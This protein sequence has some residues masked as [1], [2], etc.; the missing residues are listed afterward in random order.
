[1][2]IRSFLAFDIS[3]EMKTKLASIIS[4]LSGKVKG[5]KWVDPSL[6]HCTIRFFGNVE[7]DMLRGEVSKVIASEVR[8]Q[9]P[10]N[11][12]GR[13]IGVFPNW[14]YPEVI[15]AGLYGDTDA[16]IS[17]RAKLEEAFEKFGFQR[18]P[19]Q[20]RLHLTLG[21]A[22]GKLKNSK[23]LVQIVEKLVEREYGEIKVDSLVLYKSELTKD[24]PIYTVIEKFLLGGKR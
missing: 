10:M 4:L 2:L 7:E 11:L 24:G 1:M 17:L 15:W 12:S 6:M 23:Q 8:H 13:G 14:R 16:L 20:L 21:R 22:G 5:V 9:S 19:R 3:D 18:D